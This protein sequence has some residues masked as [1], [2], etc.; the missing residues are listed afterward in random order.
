M[1]NMSFPTTLGESLRGD[2][3][4]EEVMCAGSA[5]RSQWVSRA[6]DQELVDLVQEEVSQAQAVQTP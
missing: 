5:K 4:A 6:A 3:H 1:C 2:E